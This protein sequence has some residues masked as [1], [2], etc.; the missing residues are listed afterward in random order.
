MKALSVQQPWAWCIVHGHK[1]VENRTWPTSMRG[2]IAIHA[3][4]TLDVPAIGWIRSNF[5]EI[6]LPD[7]YDVGALI[8]TVELVDCVSHDRSRWFMGPYGFLLAKPH[9]IEPVQCRGRLG[10]FEVGEVAA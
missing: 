8:G 4:K 10:F 7:F 1:P 2:Q 3:S 9:V 5:P 6:P